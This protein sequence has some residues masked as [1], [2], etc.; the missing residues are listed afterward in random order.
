MKIYCISGLGADQQVFDGLHL[1]GEKIPVQWIESYPGESMNEYAERLCE[2]VDTAKPFVLLGVSFGGMLACEMNQFVHPVAT[3]LI[4]SM[5]RFSELPFWIRWIAKLGVQR[6]V[7]SF[8]FGSRPGVLI[9]LFGIQ[10]E[11]GKKMIRRIAISADNKF[12]KLSIDKILTWKSSDIPDN[13]F[14]IHGDKDYLLPCPKGVKVSIL[15][16]AG[17]F[18]IYENADEISKEVNLVLCDL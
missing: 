14:R 17:H 3:I 10:S 13:I 8:F 5:A 18:A 12:T 7:P 9:R 16:G 15:K 2:Q 11:Q 4:S 6:W 1:D